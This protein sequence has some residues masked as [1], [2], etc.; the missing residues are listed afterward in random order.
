[1]KRREQNYCDSTMNI[2]IPHKQD[3]LV[4]I[5][6]TSNE[7]TGSDLRYCAGKNTISDSL[8]IDFVG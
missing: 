8:W 4:I 7:Q 5:V 1:M 3:Q 2:G 6:N